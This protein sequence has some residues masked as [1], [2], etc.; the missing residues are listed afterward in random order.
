MLARLADW[1]ATLALVYQ[2]LVRL[3]ADLLSQP[4]E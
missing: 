1:Q 4:R 2:A 3:P